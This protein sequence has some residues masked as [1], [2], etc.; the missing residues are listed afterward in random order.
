MRSQWDSRVKVGNMANNCKKLKEIDESHS[1][2]KKKE[3]WGL[4]VGVHLLISLGSMSNIQSR[5]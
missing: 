2:E 4:G 1:N 5:C 3:R